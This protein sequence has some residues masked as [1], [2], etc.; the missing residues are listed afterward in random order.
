MKRP[1]LDPALEVLMIVR[2]VIACQVDVLGEQALNPGTRYLV[3]E[4]GPAQVHEVGVQ[5]SMGY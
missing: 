3:L 5:G 1:Q 2:R 4:V